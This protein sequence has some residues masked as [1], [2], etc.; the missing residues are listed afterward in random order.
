MLAYKSMYAC[1]HVCPR[2]QTGAT[3]ARLSV[4]ICV[5][6]CLRTNSASSMPSC[7]GEPWRFGHLG[8]R[9]V[10]AVVS[11]FRCTCP[12]HQRTRRKLPTS[13]TGTVGAC[14][15]RL[16]RLPISNLRTTLGC[17][18]PCRLGHVGLRHARTYAV[19]APG[20]P[21]STAARLGGAP[22]GPCNKCVHPGGALPR[23]AGTRHQGRTS[24]TTQVRHS[25][26]PSN[27]VL[28]VV[29]SGLLWP[30]AT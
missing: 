3:H 27:G 22:E 16:V 9:C 26:K 17:C 13:T 7:V 28:V 12:V 21:A 10:L 14:G 5:C 23:H 25:E 29:C 18:A 30:C 1:V 20:R 15:D 11:R 24:V 6:S 8:R 19:P 4:L 2:G